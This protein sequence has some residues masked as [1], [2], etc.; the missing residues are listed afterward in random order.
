MNDRTIIPIFVYVAVLVTVDTG[1]ARGDNLEQ[2]RERLLTA[3]TAPAMLAGD[4]DSGDYAYRR[5]WQHYHACLA[6][7]IRL[8]EAN[9]YFA[10]SNE[11]EAE[12][13]HVLLYLRTFLQYKD[14][15]LNSAARKRLA[16]ILL[17]YKE[18]A[19]R[20][21]TIERYGVSG[22]HSIVNFCIYLLTD[23]VFG[24]GPKHEVVRDKF[25]QWVRHQGRFGRDEVNS[26]HY[27]ERSFLPLLNLYDFIEDRK[28][29]LWAQMALDQMI[30]DFA[31]L[32]LNNVRGG[33]WCRAHHH[34]SPG[35]EEINNGTQDSFYII[36]YLFFGNSA[37]PTYPFTDQ[38]LSYGFLVT[39]SYRPP[40]VINNIVRVK[41]QGAYEVKSHRSPVKGSLLTS[42]QE[43]DMYYYMTPH[44]SLAA[45]QDRIELDNHL[46]NRTTKPADYV[47]TQVWELSFADPMQILGPQRRLDVATHGKT[48]VTEPNNPNTANMQYR[49]VL[50]YKGAVMDYNNNLTKGGGA[51]TEETH[52][53]RLFRYWQVTTPQG[54][55]YIGVTHFLEADAG[56][57]EVGTEENHG[58]FITFQ[59]DIK[60]NKSYCRDT[61]LETTYVSTRGDRI[62]YSHGQATVNGK[63]WPL[64]AYALYDSPYVTSVHDSGLITIG[65]KRI[66]TLT[67]D[68]RDPNTPIREI[69]E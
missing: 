4:I 18:N 63:P 62:T 58:D 13:W 59:H 3:L 65:N 60:D 46:T 51:Y 53:E 7:G 12:E 57:L 31:L 32:S 34:H 37:F 39:T 30:T 42:K 5:R 17:D 15:V 54:F 69:K 43:W 24:H 25:I 20:L 44:Y 2:R 41:R 22:N 68:F 27:L 9:R 38:I 16:E 33:P 48:P 21:K 66:G 40:E 64:H 55:V 49:N 19:H 14:T 36:G 61:G 28:L 26:P 11:L 1:V 35:V 52:G 50:F 56:I 6:K 23:Q 47:N 10:L 29:K 67:L 8:E 45:L